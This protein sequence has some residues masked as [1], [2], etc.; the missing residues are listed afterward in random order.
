MSFSFSKKFAKS[1]VATTDDT[2]GTKAT[3]VH[4]LLISRTEPYVDD[5]EL[6]QPRISR[7][8]RYNYYHRFL[9]LNGSRRKSKNELE[10]PELQHYPKVLVVLFAWI[11]SNRWDHWYLNLFLIW[12]ALV[13]AFT[14]GWV[15]KF[16][17]FLNA[18]N[19]NNSLLQIPL[20]LM[21]V[22]QV[23]PLFGTV[24]FVHFGNDLVR[25]IASK[26]FQEWVTFL[27]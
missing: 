21:L 23:I 22:T 27:Y 20:V 17:P 4:P 11:R 14:D 25:L 13:I 12:M 2:G 10:V 3:K 24:F 16:V 26:N 7:Q 9:E 6:F 8:E 18:F 19:S 15:T 5:T 1:P